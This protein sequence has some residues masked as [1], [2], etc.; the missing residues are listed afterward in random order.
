[1]KELRRLLSR[2]AERRARRQWV[3]EGVRLI[4]DAQRAGLIVR[5]L[6]VARR[7]VEAQDGDGAVAAL[8]A[9]VEQ[10]GGRVSLCSDGIVSLLA[11]TAHPQGVVALVEGELPALPSPGRLAPPVLM[12][13]GVQDPGNVGTILR[14]AAAA[15]VGAVVLDAGCADL[16]HPKVI[17]ASAGAV[18]RV[19]AAR[20]TEPGALPTLARQLRGRGWQVLG[21]EAHGGT[22]YHAVALGGPVALV[23][24]SE[25]RGIAPDLAAECS[26]FLTIPLARGIESL[27]VAA[28]VAVVLFEAARQRAGR[29]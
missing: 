10:R 23:A 25:A 4:E 2:P 21:L 24:G 16:S 12:L 11:D 19:P 5:H 17:R 9:E 14:S 29:G 18:F 6:V 28:A 13:A 1:M 15:G 3:L 20:L 22:P 7:L 27:N 8:M 26:G